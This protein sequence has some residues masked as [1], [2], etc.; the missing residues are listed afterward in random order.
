MKDQ[1]FLRRKQLMGQIGNWTDMGPGHVRGYAGLTHTALAISEYIPTCQIYIEPFA[2]LGRV[3]RHVNAEQMILNDRST[4]T[5]NY[6]KSH[7]PQA[8]ALNLDFEEI[9]AKFNYKNAV[10]VIDPV[11]KKSEYKEGCRGRA[12]CDRTP[13]EYYDTIFEWLP[14]LK[15]LWFVCGHKKNG[16]LLNSDYHKKLFESRKKIM[17]GNIKTLVISNKPFERLHQASILDS[18]A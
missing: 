5:Y 4:W 13:K 3:A 10:W 2:G 9:F 11:W 1:A 16:K 17:G 7:F 15:G 8:T 18:L 12:F 14:K 6:L